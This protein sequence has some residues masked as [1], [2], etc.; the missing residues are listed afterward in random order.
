MNHQRKLS[1]NMDKSM[2]VVYDISEGDCKIAA[3]SEGT[4]G[5]E[6]YR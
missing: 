5:A 3:T 1:V 2:T 6:V 4:K